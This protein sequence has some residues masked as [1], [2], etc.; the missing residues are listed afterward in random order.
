MRK[1]MKPSRRAAVVASISVVAASAGT[2]ATEARTP[3]MAATAHAA[4]TYSGSGTRNYSVIRVRRNSKLR[5]QNQGDPSFR[6][7]MLYDKS[8]SM[9]VSS[10][11]T[12]GMTDVEAGT[13][14]HVTV[15]GDDRWSF[16]ITP[17]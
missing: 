10:S 11:A 9:S 6:T 4:R 14:R 16:T 3:S 5:W 17:G 1:S 2:M 7:F 15:A 8:F 12:H 13:Y